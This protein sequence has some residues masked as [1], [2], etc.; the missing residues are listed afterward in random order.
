M[1]VHIWRECRRQ[2]CNHIGRASGVFRG[3]RA[4]HSS[5]G[6]HLVTKNATETNFPAPSIPAAVQ[7]EDQMETVLDERHHALRD[8]PQNLLFQQNPGLE[9]A[10]K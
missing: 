4:S 2:I 10:A 1:A 8:Q 5:Q 9:I 3:G 7:R 6:T